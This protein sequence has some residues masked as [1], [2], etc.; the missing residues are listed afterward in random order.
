MIACGQTRAVRLLRLRRLHT[1]SGRSVYPKTVG[2]PGVWRGRVDLITGTETSPNITQSETY[3]PANPD[4]PHQMSSPTTIREAATQPDQHLRRIGLHR[5]RH[6]LHPPH[7]R[8]R[9]RPFLQY[10]GRPR[11]S[12]SQANRHLVY[13]WLDTAAAARPRRVQV[14]H[15]W[16]PE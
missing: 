15:S 4:N 11:C 5:R 13:G 1:R 10:G 7:P 16:N 14:H 12:V 3:T 9:S 8:Q 6:H 2:A